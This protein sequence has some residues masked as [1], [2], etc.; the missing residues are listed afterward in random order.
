MS[1]KIIL[2]ALLLILLLTSLASAA[3]TLTIISWPAYRS[4]ALISDFEKKFNAKVNF[5]EVGTYDEMFKNL[6]KADMIIM[7]ELII[8]QLIEENR[9]LPLDKT[10]IPNIKNAEPMLLNMPYDQGNKYTLPYHYILFGL[11][12]NANKITEKEAT[13]QNYFEPSGKFKGRVVTFPEA[14]YNIGLALKYM[15]KSFN[16]LNQ[17]HLD[18]VKLLL[19]NLK[20]DVTPGSNSLDRDIYSA[21]KDV[22]T[23]KADLSISYYESEA[24]LKAYDF[25][26]QNAKLGF[27]IPEEGALFASDVMAVLKQ[28]KNAQLAQQFINFMY[29]PQ[30]AA[31]SV[32][33]LG[34]PFPVKGVEK[35]I[36]SKLSKQVY[37]PKEVLAK[38]ES[39]LPL[40]GDKVN[41]YEKIW[42]EAFGN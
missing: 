20:S 17:D 13:L 36:D 21:L 6:P 15:G 42:K 5:I 37:I 10:L 29:D 1:K 19:K 16:S 40:A 35:I 2:L 8:P 30:Y 7:G 26:P 4:P 23:G 31:K 38:C 11:V 41:L 24:S 22:A 34:Y 32:S 3:G 18:K 27:K 14:R 9:L 39:M 25:I 12:Y 33:Y 28:S